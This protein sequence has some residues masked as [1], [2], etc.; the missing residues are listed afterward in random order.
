MIDLG[1]QLSRQLLGCILCASPYI[2][3]ADY[4]RP[5]GYLHVNYTGILPISMHPHWNYFRNMCTTTHIPITH[6]RKGILP[7]H[8]HST[9]CSDFQIIQLQS[10]SIEYLPSTGKPLISNFAHNN[11]HT[12]LTP[13]RHSGAYGWPRQAEAKRHSMQG[14][15]R[16]CLPSSRPKPVILGI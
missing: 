7:H 16:T 10:A 2:S 8:S 4:T 15:I 11:V 3:S 12:A 9:I 1:P 6:A 5:L 14:N 13:Y